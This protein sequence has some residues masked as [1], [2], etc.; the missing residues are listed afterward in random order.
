MSRLATIGFDFHFWDIV[1][2]FLKGGVNKKK[3]KKNR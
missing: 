3:K 1:T 2:F